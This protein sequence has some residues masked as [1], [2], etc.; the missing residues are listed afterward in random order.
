MKRL[1]IASCIFLITGCYGGR[2]GVIRSYEDVGST[3]VTVVSDIPWEEIA[4]D[5]QPQFAFDEETAKREAL[6]VT[7]RTSQRDY[8]EKC[9]DIRAWAYATNPKF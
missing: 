9:S 2:T 1:I 4:D 6:P 8:N 7:L 3:Y 5:L